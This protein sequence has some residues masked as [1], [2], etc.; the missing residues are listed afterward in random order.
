MI[1]MATDLRP[2]VVFITALSCEFKAVT[3]FLTDLKE[4]VLPTGTIYQIGK[5]QGQHIAIAEVGQT[6]PRAAM[7]TERAIEYFKPRYAFFV[8]VAGGIKDVKLGD[9]VAADC[10]KGYQRGKNDEEFLPRSEV[11]GCDYALVQ[12]AKATVMAKKW[13]DKITQKE[14]LVSMPE[15]WVAPIAAGEEVVTSKKTATYERL[16]KLYSDAVAVEM[17][18]LG[19]LTA[20]N[21]G[22]DVK[23]IVI[24][25][26]SDRLTDKKADSDKKW[27]PI[28]AHHAAAFA[29]AMLDELIQPFSL[30][31]KLDRKHNNSK[32]YDL[33]AWFW[34]YK[35]K[36][37]KQFD[38]QRN[39]E[40]NELPKII[41]KIV[42]EDIL[43]VHATSRD[44]FTVEFFL[45]R[46]LLSEPINEW[47]L[48][49]NIDEQ[50]GQCLKWVVRSSERFDNLVSLNRLNE[51]WV[52]CPDILG[53][54][55]NGKF[56][57]WS[58]QENA[59]SA[60][61]FLHQGKLLFALGFVPEQGFLSQLISS[62]APFL[63]WPHQCPDCSEEKFKELLSDCMKL[64]QLPATL[65]KK[66]KNAIFTPTDISHYVSL[67]FDDPN[68][69]PPFSKLTAPT[70]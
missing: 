20:T 44:D 29:F 37:P 60:M 19:F 68:K 58:S 38:A 48:D 12:R 6:N 2:T 36:T 70:R 3:K 30:I 10:V 45:P 8:G 67:L 46:D 17:E 43:R 63:L 24:R 1:V 54:N 50:V 31:I 5:Y 59:K 28:A 25:G 64:E 27:Q 21:A 56:Q 26:I 32:K 49:E 13:L 35:G 9:V 69:I 22:N 33:Q 11:V 15:A 34:D 4:E 47:V 51:C 39:C 7:E 16:K 23:A 52:K 55:P 18:G 66:R 41:H 61:A 53:A 42:H 62:G 14:N 57:H 40:K 65:L